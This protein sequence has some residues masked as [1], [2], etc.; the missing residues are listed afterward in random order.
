M[1]QPDLLAFWPVTEPTGIFTSPIYTE[2]KKGAESTPT[3]SLM[4][5]RSEVRRSVLFRLRALVGAD[6]LDHSPT[7]RHGRMRTAVYTTL[8]SVEHGWANR[9]ANRAVAATVIHNILRRK[10]LRRR[11]EI[12][13]GGTRICD[14]GFYD[15]TSL[16]R[17]PF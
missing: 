14:V 7:P 4:S 11:R 10:R 12:Y 17:K 2:V 6:F 9:L 15:S 5:A 13:L 3:T 1:L 8:T 16:E